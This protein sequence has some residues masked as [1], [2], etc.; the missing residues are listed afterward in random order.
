MDFLQIEPFNIIGIS[1]RTDN[2]DYIKLSNDIQ[3]LWHKFIS[4]NIINI[5][6]RK[7]NNNIYCLYTD[8]EADHTKP[9]S[10]ILGCMVDNLDTIPDGLVGKNFSG[11]KY[12]KHTAKGSILQGV[13]FEK[14][15]HIWSLDTP[16]SYIADFEVYSEKAQNIE[17]AEV[18]IFI[19][20]Q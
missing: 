16:R 4:E 14:W 11:G 13:V 15:K 10:A 2:S 12:N 3:N 1:V 8:Y 9:Y 19:G 5:I 20:I 17:N 18:E 6:P 7:I